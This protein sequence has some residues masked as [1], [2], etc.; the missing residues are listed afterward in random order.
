[1]TENGGK[2]N[3]ETHEGVL[4]NAAYLNLLSENGLSSFESFISIP[5][6]KVVKKVR[7]D[8]HTGL[9]KL[10]S[11]GKPVS[12]YLKVSNYS[13]LANFFKT[14]R[15]FT[16]Q[17][18]SLVHEYLNLVRLREIGVPSIT[19]IAAGTRRKGFKCESFILT[20]DLGDT[21]KLEDYI[22]S[23]FSSPFSKEQSVRKKTLIGKIAEIT[24]RMHEG[25]I[26]HRDFYLCH[27][28]ILL[29]AEP[30][31]KLFVIDLN[32][33]DRRE[34]VGERWKV[35]DLAALNYSAPCE[36]F[37]KADRLRFL[38]LYLECDKLD[39]AK[40]DFIYK[41]V[42]KTEK[43]SRHALRSKEKDRRYM[44]KESQKP[45]EG[46]CSKGASS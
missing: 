8:R 40:K 21:R 44:E 5:I 6:K 15:K 9:I 34:H 27:L 46:S 31:P 23:E 11:N 16:R 19:P 14:I 18:S 32:R 7:D 13:W 22:P 35:K 39:K 33:A 25:G 17:R 26:N 2:I 45:R 41:I 30:W 10:I 24:R 28:H 42:R 1:M 38:F 20:Q 29:K 4:V 43:I 36:I 37:S 12:A 3:T